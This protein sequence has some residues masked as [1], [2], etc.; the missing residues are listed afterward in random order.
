MRSATRSKI[1]LTISFVVF[2][3]FLYLVGFFKNGLHLKQGQKGSEVPTIMHND[4]FCILYNFLDATDTFRED[5]L[6]PV[7]LAIHGTSEMMKTI[8]AKPSNWDGPISLGLFLDFHSTNALEY[9]S[10]LHRCDAEFQRKVTVHFAFRISPFQDKCPVYIEPTENIECEEFLKNRDK[11]RNSIIGSFQLYPSNLMRN[12]ARRGA[13]SDIHFIADVDMVMSENFATKIKPIANEMIDGKNKKL[14][15]VRRFETNSTVI[16][17]NHK[18]LE[19]AVKINLV[20]EFHRKFFFAGHQIKNLSDWFKISDAS[21]TISAWE[22]PYSSSSWEIQPILHRND[23]YN[24]DYFPARMRVMQSL[25]YSSCRAGYTFH[26]LSHVFDVHEGVKLDDTDYSKSVISHSK[27]Y[28]RQ[29]A[30][31]RYV[32]EMNEKYPDTIS[33]CGTF[34]M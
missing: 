17:K 7:T 27:K 12:I 30:Y 25:I 4:E 20:N 23:L 9:I 26:L 24:A 1:W 16:P 6:E 22:I 32:K 5:G 33:R 34:V 28:G 11:Y 14:L 29:I 15:V 21:D 10:N 3:V 13:K 31:D 8:E 18:E 19:I 2:V